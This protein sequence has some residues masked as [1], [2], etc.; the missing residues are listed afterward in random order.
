MNASE[1]GLFQNTS[2]RSFFRTT[3]YQLR[4]AGRDVPAQVWQLSVEHLGCWQHDERR[5][6]QLR[7]QD[8]GADFSSKT[9][10]PKFKS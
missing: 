9:T 7:L 4:H 3:G 10:Y 2:L 5:L 8:I 6:L 1:R